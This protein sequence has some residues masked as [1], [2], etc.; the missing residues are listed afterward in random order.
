M[1]Q[2]FFAGVFV[3]KDLVLINSLASLFPYLNVSFVIA[4]DAKWYSLFMYI[5]FSNI[6]RIIIDLASDWNLFS[7]IL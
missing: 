6:L 7:P 1:M 3:E 5:K 2:N 4:K